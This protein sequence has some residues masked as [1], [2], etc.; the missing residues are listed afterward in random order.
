VDAKQTMIGWEDDWK[1][2]GAA[3]IKVAAVALLATIAAAPAP[4]ETAEERAIQTI[5]ERREES[6]ERVHVSVGDPAEGFDGTPAWK[7]AEAKCVKEGKLLGVR[8]YRPF[9]VRHAHYWCVPG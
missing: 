8:I 1:P 2:E 5:A 6:I 4:Q 9:G 3:V 7:A